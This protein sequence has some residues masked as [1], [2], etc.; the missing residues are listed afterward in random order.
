MADLIKDARLTNSCF[1]IQHGK[2]VEILIS[3]GNSLNIPKKLG[4]FWRS[5]QKNDSNFRDFPP[6]L[7]QMAHTPK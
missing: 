4:H 1:A 6:F 7:P 5:Y 2:E 3:N